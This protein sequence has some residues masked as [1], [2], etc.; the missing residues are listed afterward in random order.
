MFAFLVASQS[1]HRVT[2][3]CPSWW[4]SCLKTARR[5][6]QAAPLPFHTPLHA[7]LLRSSR[8]SCPPARADS[9]VPSLCSIFLFHPVHQEKTGLFI[10]KSETCLIIGTHADH[11]QGGNCSI[12]VGNLADYLLNCGY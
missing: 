8:T 7:L 1:W 4:C 5:V 10:V 6:F 2:F 11:I 3:Y 9:L 12:V